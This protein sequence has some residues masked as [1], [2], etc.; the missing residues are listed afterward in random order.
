M[1]TALQLARRAHCRAGGWL[2]LAHT[3]STPEPWAPATAGRPFR[4]P[5]FFPDSPTPTGTF[6]PPTDP[7]KRRVWHVR[8]RNGR[9][10]PSPH[11]LEVRGRVLPHG[12]GRHRPSLHQA[13]LGR[14]VADGFTLVGDTVRCATVY[15]FT[16]RKAAKR[17]KTRAG[18][19]PA[20]V[21]LKALLR[22]MAPTP[23]GTPRLGSGPQPGR[24]RCSAAGHERLDGRMC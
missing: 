11:R 13:A 4:Q 2:H 8:V 10:P 7:S 19:T 3:L 15:L 24:I 6:V 21:P 1:G 5:S 20:G 22:G 23:A 18:I 9:P 12:Q 14:A 16:V 17:P